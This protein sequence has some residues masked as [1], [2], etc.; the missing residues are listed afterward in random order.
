MPVPFYYHA[1][2]AATE[3]LCSSAA[4]EDDG[5]TLCR[6]GCR[7]PVAGY[8]SAASAATLL[9][10]G[11]RRTFKRPPRGENIHGGRL[12]EDDNLMQQDAS[13]R[14]GGSGQAATICAVF[15]L[16]RGCSLGKKM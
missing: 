6:L 2:P 14:S 5:A 12:E 8:S 16:S 3:P 9:R 11:Y 1:A 15:L 4:V 13:G 7:V 10:P